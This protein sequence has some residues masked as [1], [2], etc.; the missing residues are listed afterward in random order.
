MNTSPEN[1]ILVVLDSLR[2]E[3]LSCYG[4]NKNTT[5]FIDQIAENG[6]KL[7]AYSTAP[8][9]V[10]VH[11]TLFT[12]MLPSY[13]GSH[14]KSKQFKLPSEQS[15][16]GRL[17]ANGYSTAGFSAN[18]W[19]SPEFDFDTGFN[20]YECFSP[21][22]PFPDEEIYPEDESA[23]LSSM[24]GIASIVSWA[25]EGNALKRIANGFW[26]RYFRKSFV[27]SGTVNESID[28]H[29]ESTDETN[30][31]IFANYM[32]VHDP[33]YE[34]PLSSDDVDISGSAFQGTAH[35][36]S[37][38]YP[39]VEQRINFQAE[40]DDP[41]QGRIL[42]DQSINAVDKGVSELYSLLSDQ[43][44]IDE[45][46]IIILG[47]HGE[48]M[49]EDNYWGHGTYLHDQLLRV[50]LII[51]PPASA[52]VPSDIGRG[53]VS[54]LS[55]YEFVEAAGSGTEKPFEERLENLID[56]P[57]LFAE[58]TGPRPNME[59]TASEDGYQAVVSSG[60]KL[61]RNRTTG[62]T[63]LIK[64]EDDA[65]QGLGRDAAREHL[66][67]LIEE[68]WDREEFYKNDSDTSVSSDTEQRLSDL[69]YM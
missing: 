30:N 54:L 43:I 32:E 42:Y 66:T 15:L 64:V 49:G 6:I 69:G 13:H 38:R 8:W 62:D 18:P 14:R 16:A 4:Y 68:R 65:S 33:H 52:E 53:P 60:W 25:L 5:P 27:T 3:N 55:I 21:I 24:S 36:R 1:I 26:N 17:S 29:L 23:N 48:C 10:P 35:T 57:P 67:E 61:I 31:F 46:L 40:P 37:F 39:F 19:L 50:P 11:G 2:S 59:G 28:E 41:D 51:D 20:H 9:T 56:G 34:P 44:N 63:E 12:G 7:D 45:S 22:T 47:D 58:C